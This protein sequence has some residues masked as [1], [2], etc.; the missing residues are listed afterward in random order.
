MDNAITLLMKRLIKD[1][2]LE[3]YR[4]QILKV[5]SSIWEKES[6]STELNIKPL[7]CIVIDLPLLKP[8]EGVYDEI[9]KIVCDAFAVT[10][11]VVLGSEYLKRNLPKNPTIKLINCPVLP[12]SIYIDEETRNK[13]LAEQ[14][15]KYFFG[16]PEKPLEPVV[17]K[18]PRS[19]FKVYSFGPLRYISSIMLMLNEI[20]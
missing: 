16:T 1:D 18:I 17:M 19:E 2:Y 6:H 12:G 9:A 13:L 11:I 10:H 15:K 8:I 20:L 5:Q 3:L 14:I 7:N 4:D